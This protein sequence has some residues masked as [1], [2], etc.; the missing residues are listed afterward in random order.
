MLATHGLAVADTAGAP[1][2]LDSTP[3]GLPLYIRHGWKPVDEIR[4]NLEKYGYE[5][6]GW[7]VE[8]CLLREPGAGV[9]MPE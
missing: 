8:K 2:Y 3:A 4:V 5:G 9:L 1:I 6:K 7:A